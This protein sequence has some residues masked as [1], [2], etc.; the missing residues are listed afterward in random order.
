M[1]LKVAVLGAS[2]MVGREIL[3][4][5]AERLITEFPEYYPYFAMTEFN[6]K[7]R[8]PA[9]SRNRNPLLKISGTDWTTD[10]HGQSVG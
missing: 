9:N 2:G 10:C 3:G 4:I 7:D 5:L 8:S 1:A 6:F